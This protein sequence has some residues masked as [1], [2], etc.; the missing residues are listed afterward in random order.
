MLDND[1]T[2][3]TLSEFVKFLFDRPANQTFGEKLWNGDEYVRYNPVHNTE[4]FT[5]LFLNSKTLT[6]GYSRQQCEQ[7]F[8]AIQGCLLDGAVSELLWDADIPFSLRQKMIEST[9]CLYRDFFSVDALHTACNMFF[10]GLIGVSNEERTSPDQLMMNDV[11]FATLCKILY[12]ESEDCQAAALH[13]LNHLKHPN[14]KVVIMK[15]IND[16][17]E[18]CSHEVEYCL[19]CIDGNNM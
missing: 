1:L 15:Y 9:Y 7:A 4:L 14:N 16:H 8:W 18:M 6:E 13:G 17:P 11:L 12:L 19:D 5:A 2:N 10:D 3:A